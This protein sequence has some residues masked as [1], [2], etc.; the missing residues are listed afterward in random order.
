VPASNPPPRRTPW[1]SLL[2]A[3]VVIGLAIAWFTR[4]D[5][6]FSQRCTASVNGV[7]YTLD[8][9]QARNAALIAVIGAQR[10][11]PARASSIAIATAIQESKLRNIDYGDRDSLGL[12]QQRPS[13]GWGTPEQIMDPVYATNAFYD[14]LVKIEGFESLPITDAAQKVQRSGFPQAYADNEPEARAYA[15]ALTGHSP[16]ALSCR[17]KP[18]TVDAQPVGESGLTARSQAVVAAATTEVGRVD[19]AAGSSPSTI[20]ASANSQRQ[21]WSLAQWAVAGADDLDIVEVRVA[22]R[23]WRRD[24]GADAAWVAAEPLADGRVQIITAN[25]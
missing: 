16:A 18:V 3:L 14:V 15:S 10:G 9:D 21:A 25:G 17:L 19:T 24:D 22:D 1:A 8:P 5:P 2:V 11:L 13:Q 7:D 4:S 23:V 20:D 6:V 12:F